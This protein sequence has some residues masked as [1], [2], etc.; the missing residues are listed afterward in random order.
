MANIGFVKSK[1]TIKPELIDEMLERI[2]QSHFKGNL[3]IENHYYSKHNDSWNVSYVSSVDSQH[4]ATRSFWLKTKRIFEMSHGGGGGDFAWWLD[5]TII[6]EVALMCDGIISDEGISDK[7]KG[8]KNYFPTY[9]LFLE[10]MK[11]H[12]QKPE[13]KLWL[14]QEEMKYCPPEHKVDLGEEVQV[15]IEWTK[16]AE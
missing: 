8:E 10:M 2:N 1:K 7:W 6:N 11:S 15:K 14:L 4:Y 13:I 16:D 3:V 12:V 5:N 9:L